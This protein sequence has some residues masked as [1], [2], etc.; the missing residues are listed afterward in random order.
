MSAC[1]TVVLAAG[2]SCHLEHGPDPVGHSIL[3]RAEWHCSAISGEPACT[4]SKEFL[5]RLCRPVQEGLVVLSALL[6]GA[7]PK[8]AQEFSLSWGA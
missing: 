5:P 8:E 2:M 4:V 1:S 6:P 3:L 7:R